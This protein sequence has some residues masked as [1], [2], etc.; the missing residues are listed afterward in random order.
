MEIL[1]T[2]LPNNKKTSNLTKIISQC[3][4]SIYPFHDGSLED[5]EPVFEK[6][7]A[8]GIPKT[9]SI[10]PNPR[11]TPTGKHQRRKHRR[12]H[13]SLPPN[14]NSA[15]ERSRNSPQQRR[16]RPR[17]RP[18]P[19]RSSHPP[20]LALPLCQSINPPRDI[21]QAGGV[22]S[23]EASVPESRFSMEPHH[24]RGSDSTHSPRRPRRR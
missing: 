10:H 8:V 14:R 18:L 22:R 20:H 9:Q 2:S 3:S 5:F 13:R 24:H 7:I 19:P 23:S 4:K 16:P 11:L 17:R 1:R 12:L 15:R 6:L 21:H